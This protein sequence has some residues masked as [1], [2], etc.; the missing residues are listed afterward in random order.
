[1]LNELSFLLDE[2]LN[3]TVAE[4]GR[5]FGL[6]VVSVHEIDRRGFSDEEQF[7]FAIGRGR[8]LVTRNRDDFLRL[9]K[10]IYQS[11]DLHRL[12]ELHHGLRLPIVP[13]SLPNNRPDRIARSLERWVGRVGD[14]GLHFV[15]F[16]SA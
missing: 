9:M 1:M 14:L 4:I 5:S 2:D 16:L 6:D 10:S 3:P 7:R 8:T 15:D 11:E 13:H 12:E